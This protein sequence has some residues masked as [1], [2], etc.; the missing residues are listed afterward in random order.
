MSVDT[1]SVISNEH[2]RTVKLIFA[3]YMGVETIDGKPRGEDGSRLSVVMKGPPLKKNTIRT[4]LI[5]KKSKFG[6]FGNLLSIPENDAK[7]VHQ[8]GHSSSP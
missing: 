5:T 1:G 4:T 6:N 8:D 3:H 7:E 2:S